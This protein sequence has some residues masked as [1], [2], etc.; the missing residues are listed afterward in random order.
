M[1]L[2][3]VKEGCIAI[4]YFIRMGDCREHFFLGERLR[5]LLNFLSSNMTIFQRL[6]LLNV[7]FGKN[8]K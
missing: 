5:M 3:R 4:F 6:N 7:A 8:R 2:R 1:F